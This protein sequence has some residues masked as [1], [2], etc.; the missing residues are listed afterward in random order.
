MLKKS[1]V[2]LLMC[3]LLGCTSQDDE[4]SFKYVEEGTVWGDGI[5]SEDP[6]GAGDWE[7]EEPE[8]SG[9]TEE[10]EEE[11]SD[12]TPEEE[13]S[14]EVAS[15]EGCSNIMP[16]SPWTP[17]ENLSQPCNFRLTDQNGDEVELYDFE[18]SVIL[19]DFSTMWC[20]VCKVV[21]GHVQD[22]ND[23]YDP[24]VAITVLTQTTAGDPPETS[25]LAD[26]ATA[27]GITTAPVLGGNDE[28]IGTEPE[29]WWVQAWPTFYL[30]DK[31]FMV[32]IYQ[33]GWNENMVAGYIEDLLAE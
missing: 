21:A 19:L 30:I 15:Y 3:F 17:P 16:M 33:P 10:S 27:Y 22:L 20:S 5:V 4:A 29:E 32:R 13:T 31:D 11:T 23:Q 9:G 12:E 25:D 1:Y 28:M 2:M 7:D 14:D 24:F 8:D 26:W 18:G 6:P